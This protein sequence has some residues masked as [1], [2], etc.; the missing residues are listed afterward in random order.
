MSLWG[1]I[2]RAEEKNEPPEI[3]LMIGK[4]KEAK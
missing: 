1:K 3:G 4:K 2:Y